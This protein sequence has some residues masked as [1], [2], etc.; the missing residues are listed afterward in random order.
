MNDWVVVGAGSA[1]T[2]VAARL[3]EDPGRRVVL[4]EAGPAGSPA[5]TTTPDAAMPRSAS[6][7]SDLRRPGRTHDE[8]R[9]IRVDGGSPV[10]Y[11]LGRGVGGS[12]EVN[13]MIGLRG[14]PYDEPHLVPTEVPPPE[15]LGH[16]DRALLA[17]A[18]DAAPVPLT[19]RAGRR[20]SVADAYLPDA[21]TRP[22]LQIRADAPVDRVAFAGRA[23]AGVV[24]V[25]GTTVPADRVVVCAGAIHTPALLLR[26]GVDTPGVGHG[27]MDHPS[28]P[29]TLAL[30]PQAVSPAD[31]LAVGS[32]LRRGDIQVLP[33]NHLGDDTHAFGILMP[34]LMRVHSTG[35]V[36]LADAD[37]ATPPHVEFRMLS[38]PRDLRALV[39]AVE[40]A[41]G[42]LATRPFADIVETVYVDDEGTTIDTL[43]HPDRIA[44]WLPDHVGDYVHASCSCRMGVVVDDACRVRGYHGLMVCDASVFPEIPLVNTNLP[45]VMLAE[46]MAARWRSDE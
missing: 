36:Q 24:L 19:R 37:P 43:D 3:S 42:L 45:I 21:V 29:L 2:V 7:F 28:A 23:A 35:R 26:S 22:N 18:P 4:L 12:S 44:G 31:S 38:D 27:L 46:A 25:D 9:V 13:A 16:V 30:R 6:F 8:L 39:G 20:V 41:V 14:G 40:V 11:A 15:D 5:D 1:G 32:L 34:A 17:A 33:L 10:P